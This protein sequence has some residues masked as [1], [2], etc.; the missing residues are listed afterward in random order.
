MNLQVDPS[1]TLKS[2]HTPN[3]TR[4]LRNHL[5]STKTA[6]I[7]HK[8]SNTRK[9][10]GETNKSRAPCGA[11]V[12]HLRPDNKPLINIAANTTGADAA[13]AGG[14]RGSRRMKAVVVVG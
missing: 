7:T 4:K 9:K 5:V 2:A 8:L 3:K 13:G 12:S 11:E 1:D 10:L 6:Q 14:R